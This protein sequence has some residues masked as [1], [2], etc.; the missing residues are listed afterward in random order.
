MQQ[1]QV[2]RAKVQRGINYSGGAKCNRAKFSGP[3]SSGARYNRAK[4]S[5]STCSGAK[6]SD[7]IKCSGYSECSRDNYSG[8]IECSGVC[9]QGVR[10]AY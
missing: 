10:V 1:G 6:C 5:G 8:D 7:D 9:A 3:T 2:Q 4:Y